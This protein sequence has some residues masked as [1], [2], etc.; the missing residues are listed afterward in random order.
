MLWSMMKVQDLER[1]NLHLALLDCTSMDGVFSG[2]QSCSKVENL[3]AS[4]T[5]S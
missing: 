1:Q 4:L 3:N 5:V 2:K